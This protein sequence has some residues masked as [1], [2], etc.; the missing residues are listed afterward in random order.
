MSDK[1]FAVGI[2]SLQTAHDKWKEDIVALGV[3]P[4]TPIFDIMAWAREQKIIGNI[5]LI[6][7]PEWLAQQTPEVET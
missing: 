2:V 1:Y 6:P 5:S 3:E 4:E 7:A